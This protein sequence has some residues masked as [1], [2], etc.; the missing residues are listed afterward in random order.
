MELSLKAA[1]VNAEL[2][3]RQVEEKTGF[4]RSTLTRWE[5]GK[6]SPRMC[7]LEILCKLYGVPT[8]CIRLK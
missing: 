1:R 4:A 3:Q 6:A 7:N 5:R 8:G 2:T